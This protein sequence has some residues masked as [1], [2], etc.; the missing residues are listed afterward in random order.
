MDINVGNIKTATVEELDDIL[1]R[2]EYAEHGVALWGAAADQD[3]RRAAQAELARRDGP[4]WV[5]QTPNR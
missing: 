3:L 2:T 5:T 1:E 4:E